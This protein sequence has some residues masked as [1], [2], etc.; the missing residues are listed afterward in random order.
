MSTD[1]YRERFPGS[2]VQFHTKNSKR[3]LKHATEKWLAEPENRQKMLARRSFPSE[4]KHWL[5]KGYSEAEAR[6]LVS[7]HQTKLAMRQ[8][9][10]DVKRRQSKNTS[11][12]RNPMSLASIA[13][14]HNVSLIEASRLTPC[15]GRTGESHPMY[16]KH[17]SPDSL[18]KIALN[19]SRSF[20]QQS[21]AEKEI[22]VAFR[23]NDLNFKTHVG[24]G[25][26][27]CDFVFESKK[28]IV[29]YFGDFWH[30]NPALWEHDQKH[31]LAKFTAEERW[32][33]DSEKLEYLKE[34]GYDVIVIWESEWNADPASCIKRVINA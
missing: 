27:N 33:Y 18:E 6:E 30:C 19:A 1:E 31:P 21:K 4:I 17:H 32:K 16:G 11:G 29:E 25:R 5:R 10:P 28:L 12:D 24:I 13:A 34:A 22:G 3:K 8:N 15:F 7:K 20:S 9:R 14:R 23:E 2:V 26:Y